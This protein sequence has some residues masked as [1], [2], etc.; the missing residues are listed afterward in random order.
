MK[1]TALAFAAVACL[2]C[3]AEETDSLKVLMIGNS[4]SI[5]ATRHMPQ[6]A[7]SMGLELDLASLYIGGCSLE[8]HRDNCVK[9]EKDPSFRPYR[10]T[11]FVDGEKK[12]DRPAN[13]PEALA[14][15]KWDVVTIQQASH[16]SWQLDTYRPFGDELIKKYIKPLA[17]QAEVVV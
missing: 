15:E 2:V 13:V 1:K 16:F 3:P 8:R 12:E 6:V 11:R 9:G 4:F 7:K 17:P 14:L 5:S 10:F